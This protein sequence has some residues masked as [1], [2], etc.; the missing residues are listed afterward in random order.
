MVTV[1]LDL[2]STLLALSITFAA[3]V[4]LLSALGYLKRAS[5][6]APPVQAVQEQLSP[7]APSLT[8][9]QNAPPGWGQPGYASPPPLFQAEAYE[10]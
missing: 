9:H 8:T 5:P 3:T 6:P 10:T 4:H 1:Q 2:S 7:Q